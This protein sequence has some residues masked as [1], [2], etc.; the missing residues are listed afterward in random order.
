MVYISST[1]EVLDKEP[2]SWKTPL[3]ILWAIISF[4]IEFF[5]TMFGLEHY[6]R[7]SRI[8][9]YFR[10]GSWSSSGGSGY[11]FRPG[12][13]GGGGNGPSGGGGG[14]PFFSSGINRRIGTLPRNSGL[15]V[16][17]CPGGAC[18]R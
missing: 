13:G 4:V 8:N 9:R 14:R 17:S 10:G 3:K 18:G 2:L 1:G 12:G 15:G 16:P 7:E 11:D 6:W 5:L